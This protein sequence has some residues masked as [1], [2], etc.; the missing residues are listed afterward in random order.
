MR[1]S[2]PHGYN[3]LTS[4]WFPE[5][6]WWLI[7]Q[8]TWIFSSHPDYFIVLWNVN[9]KDQKAYA[10]TVYSKIQ[11]PVIKKFVDIN[12]W[13][14][15]DIF[16]LESMLR[17][18]WKSD[19]SKFQLDAQTIMSVKTDS[20]DLM[21]EIYKTVLYP[22]KELQN[23][24]NIYRIWTFLTYFISENRDRFYDDSLVMNFWKY[25]YDKDPNVAISKMEKL[26]IKYFLVDLNA[27]TIDKDPRHDLTKRF[28]NLLS[29]FRSDKL[30]LVQ[31]DSPCLRIAIEEKNDTFLEMAW[32]NYE[33]YTA[34]WQVVWRQIKQ[35]GCY[36]HILGLIKNWKIDEAHY[37]YLLPLAKY[38]KQNN[39]QDQEKLVEV[40]QQYIWH[41]WLVLFKIK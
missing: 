16:S 24:W 22:P 15:Y 8:E 35:M 30:E 11:N 9:L 10:K 19:L 36:N 28:E 1:S 27:A 18:L 29:T 3:N 32:V 34:S 21:N 26:G 37:S 39:I 20:T 38:L 31:T 4:S 2:L 23:T 17:E 40:F 12:L 5:F 14:N 41:G 13:N 25:F 7:T 33:S 6:K